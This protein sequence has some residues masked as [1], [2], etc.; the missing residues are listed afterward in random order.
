MAFQGFPVSSVSEESACSEG[1]P[2][3]IPGSGR[4]SGEGNRN[5]LQYFYLE[6]SMDREAWHATV[7]AVAK[8]QTQLSD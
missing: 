3:S 5:P 7:Y 4:S 1:D 6:K 8:H 2:G